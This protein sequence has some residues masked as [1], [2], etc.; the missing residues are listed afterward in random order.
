V[1]L[2]LSGCR[3]FTPPPSISQTTPASSTADTSTPAAT[4]I[5]APTTALPAGAPEATPAGSGG[6]QGQATPE[7]KATFDRLAQANFEASDPIALAIE[8]KGVPGPIE[9]VLAV[10]EPAFNVGA[11]RSFWVK[12]H[13]TNEWG[14]IEAR[15]ERVTE[16]AY[17]WF[18]TA[19]D[20]R[21]ES[22]YDAAAQA[23]EQMYAPTRAVY[24]SEWS[25]GIDG[26]PRVYVLHA[27]AT[28]LCNV[29]EAVAHQCGVLGYFSTTDELP[30]A[31]EPH[32]NQHELFVMNLDRGKIGGEQYLL[33]LVH[34]FRHMIEY[35]YDRHD[36][37]WE[38]EGTAM[39][40]EDLL[41]YPWVPGAYGTSYTN[42]GTDLQLNAW[43]VGNA[44]PHYGKGY[45]FS[46]YI[47]HRMGPEFY[48]A[49]V[50]HP[51]R[52]FF[53]LD[54]VL[55]ERSYDF[56]AHDLWLDWTAAVSLIGFENIPAD[57]SFG[58]NFEVE[59]AEAKKVNS[60][61]EQVQEQVSQYAFDVYEVDGEQT[62]LVNF[63]GAARVAVLEN[64]LPAS[65]AAYWWSGRANQSDMN[66]TRAV[67]L[68]GVDQATL[69]YSVYYDIERGYDFAYAVLSTDGG[70]TWESLAAPNMEGVKPDDDPGEAALTD[71]FYTGSSSGWQEETVD[72]TPY[73]GQEIYL[74]FQYVTDPI[75]TGPGIALDNIA[76]PEIGY[77]D[78]AETPAGGWEA[79][80]FVR[81]TAYEPQRFHL[82]LI[83][84]GADGGW[85]VEEI[86][87]AGDNT[88][89]FEIPLTRTSRRALLIVAASNPL[90]LTPASYQL[91]FVK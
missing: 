36:D 4:K 37:D 39:M 8:L 77:Y 43:S 29:T 2:A 30:A 67:D 50:Q 34:E 52:G 3:G 11:V 79:N 55:K 12:N 83:T 71:R 66:L 72:L 23:F 81:V 69:K 22:D 9:P 46:R 32:S 64:L 87:L 13:D 53:A 14:W 5:A 73:A 85:T 84:S 89:Q 82:R 70:E 16:H 61:P 26:D 19:G 24:G 25:P 10:G 48:S 6:D 76:I 56:D 1:L 63:T 38:V 62:I 45:V 18:D 35:N 78:D 91:T 59:P 88:A 54:A 40:A 42:E 51:E 28:A 90:I 57:Y 44:V 7:E 80:G 49:W 33:T 31:V 86:P 68:A 74:R 20:R 58:E 75:F 17:L 15:L 41:G 65:G 21:S 47:Y 27:N 60:F